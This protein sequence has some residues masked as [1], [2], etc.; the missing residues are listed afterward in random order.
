MKMLS[1]LL[2]E[3]SLAQ[4]QVLLENDI[5][6]SPANARLRAALVQLL[7][8]SGNWSRALTQLKSWQALAPQAEPT[9][10]LLEQTIAAEQRRE[11]VL[12]GQGRPSMAENDWPW[13]TLMADALSLP[14]TQACALREQAL[15]HACA[16]PGILT[17]TDNKEQSFNWL[18]DGDARFGPVC[19]VFVNER[20][21]WLPFSAIAHVTF[22]APSSAFDLIWRHCHIQLHNGQEQTGQIPLRYPVTDSQADNLLLARATQ[23][24][25]LPGSVNQNTGCGQK[26]LTGESG[27]YSLCNLQTL[28]FRKEEVM[29]KP[30]Q[31]NV[32]ITHHD[33][34][35]R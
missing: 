9:V 16:P 11:A 18:L 20:Y 14:A 32:A 19:E 21:F 6:A 31:D 17:Q 34:Q 13:L 15:E 30:T 2:S 27:A 10:T 5:K 25:P 4:A 1:Q 22:Q 29:K 35:P 3:N 23:W 33:W 24:Q 28:R 12:S 8:L 26:V 7:C